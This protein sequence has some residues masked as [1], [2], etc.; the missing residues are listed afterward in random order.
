M[1]IQGEAEEEL[2][3]MLLGAVRL[4]NLDVGARIKI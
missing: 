1:V 2:P 3:E 4:D